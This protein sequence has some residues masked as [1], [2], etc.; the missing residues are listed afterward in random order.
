MLYDLLKK[1]IKKILKK[2]FTKQKQDAIISH[3]LNVLTYFYQNLKN[4]YRSDV[5]YFQIDLIE[6]KEKKNFVAPP[7]HRIS[8]SKS[9]Y[10]LCFYSYFELAYFL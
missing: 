9:V 2:V 6:K 1:Y 8:F 3:K 7:K 5:Y 4:K 10:L